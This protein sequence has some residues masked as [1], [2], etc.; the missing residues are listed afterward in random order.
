MKAKTPLIHRLVITRKG[1][2]HTHPYVIPIMEITIYT[3]RADLRNGPL[4]KRWFKVGSASEIS[5][6]RRI[7][8]GETYVVSWEVAMYSQAGIVIQTH[9]CSRQTSKTVPITE[10]YDQ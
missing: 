3:T 10:L 2:A 8:V 4:L 6:Q 9:Y 5:G 7:S 1:V